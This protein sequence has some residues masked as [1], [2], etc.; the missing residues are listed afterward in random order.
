MT[1]VLQAL[2]PP[3]TLLRLKGPYHTNSP[4]GIQHWAVLFFTHHLD[5]CVEELMCRDCEIAPFRPLS[6]YFAVWI[7]LSG[8]LKIGYFNSSALLGSESPS[9]AAVPFSFTEEQV[10]SLLNVGEERI[11]PARG[12]IAFRPLLPWRPPPQILPVSRMDRITKLSV[13]RE[14]E[15]EEEWVF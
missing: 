8:I 7:S 10:P 6:S 1:L 3:C 9:K 11:K 12:V 5:L 13:T 4:S 2:N 14:E 15:E